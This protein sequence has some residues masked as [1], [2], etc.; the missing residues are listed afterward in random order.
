MTLTAPTPAASPTAKQAQT[1]ARAAS[2]Q[3]VH[4]SKVPTRNGSAESTTAARRAPYWDRL[5]A[6]GS[7]ARWNTRQVMQLRK[8]V[9]GNRVNK[10]FLLD[11]KEALEQLTG[12]F[13][14][15]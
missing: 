2:V 9:D 7:R 15:Q 4:A 6:P 3:A 8:E 12:N 5:W 10:R 13:G 11:D 1:P 14:R